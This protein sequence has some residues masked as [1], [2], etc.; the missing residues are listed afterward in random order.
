MNSLFLPLRRRVRK[1]IGKYP[2]IFY[3]T[4]GILN[5]RIN[6]MSVKPNTELVIIGFPRS[7]NTYSVL[8][9]ECMQSAKVNIAH[10]VHVPAQV[11]RGIK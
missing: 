3:S 4:Y 10:H 5:R 1:I 6:R 11:L 8:A 7:A 2:T 9:F